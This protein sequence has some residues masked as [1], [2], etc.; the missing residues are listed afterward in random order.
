MKTFSKT[1]L[2]IMNERGLRAVDLY[3]KSDVLTQQ[4]LSK[5]V[6][7]KIDDPTFSKALAIIDALGVTPSEFLARQE[8]P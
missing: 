1:M 3:R 7:G 5:L 4:Y 2:E 8:R 6:C